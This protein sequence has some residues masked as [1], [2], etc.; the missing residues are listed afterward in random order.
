MTSEKKL[1]PQNGP[2]GQYLTRV[3]N[4]REIQQRHSDGFINA[5]AMA[6]ING[7]HFKRYNALKS[8]KTFKFELSR[9]LEETHQSS[10]V[11]I[12]IF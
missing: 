2:I 11:T 7:K 1:A 8:A 4:G 6:S 3:F 9:V 10:K 5:T 12:I